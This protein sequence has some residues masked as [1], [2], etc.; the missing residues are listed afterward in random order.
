MDESLK[1]KGIEVGNFKGIEKIKVMF[2]KDATSIIGLNGSGKTS[3]IDVIQACL[4][5]V[6]QRGSKGELAGERFRFI[7]PHKATSDLKVILHDQQGDFDVVITNKLT[8][9]GNTIEIEPSDHHSLDREWLKDFLNAAFLSA[10]NF[11]ERSPQEQALLLG[12]DTSKF[13]EKIADIKT[14]ATFIRSGI[15]NIGDVPEVEKVERVSIS[16]LLAEKEEIDKENSARKLRHEDIVVNQ[17]LI[18][19]SKAKIIALKEALECEEE[20]LKALE[21]VRETL[22]AFRGY[23]NTEDIIN[24]IQGAEETNVKAQKYEDAEAWRHKKGVLEQQLKD[25]LEDQAKENEK[26]TKYIKG[27]DFGFAG[28]S[29]DDKGGLL[30]NDRRLGDFSKGEQEI[31]VANLYASLDPALKTRVIDE[32]QSLDCVNQKK[33]TEGLIDKGFQV[34]TLEVGSKKKGKGSIL[35]KNCAVVDGKKKEEKK[36]TLL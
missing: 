3:L 15:K 26:R 23:I 19:D 9:T 1:I 35:L 36:P 17:D 24:Q 10:K 14:K 32:F 28:L 13:D 21:S 2:D 25:N 29:V 8:K 31:I 7:G 12:I 6:S 27:F 5:G 11:V 18:E 20:N 30:L 34:I 22:P 33:I 16:K 4:K